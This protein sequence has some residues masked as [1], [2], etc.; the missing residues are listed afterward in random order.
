VYNIAG[1]V[2]MDINR[3]KAPTDTAHSGYDQTKELVAR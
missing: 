1:K 3:P 2:V